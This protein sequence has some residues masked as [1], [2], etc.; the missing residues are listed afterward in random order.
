M[1]STTDPLSSLQLVSAEL[2]AG[3]RHT[4]KADSFYIT[5]TSM[6]LLCTGFWDSQMRADEEPKGCFYLSWVGSLTPMFKKS[7]LAVLPCPDPGKKSASC[8]MQPAQTCLQHILLLTSLF[9]QPILS[10]PQASQSDYGLC[11]SGIAGTDLAGFLSC[12][13]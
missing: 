1:T 6:A 4:Q 11:S 9:T 8:L 3:G 12:Y 5:R 10:C 2:K 13:L 7:L